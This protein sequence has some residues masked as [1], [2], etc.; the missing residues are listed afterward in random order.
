MSA[1][2]GQAL[3]NQVAKPM[4]KIQINHQPYTHLDDHPINLAIQKIN[5]IIKLIFKPAKDTGMAGP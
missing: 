4:P 3:K 2:K 1:S 5:Y